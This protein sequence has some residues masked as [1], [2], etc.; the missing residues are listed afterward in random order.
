LDK[1]VDESKFRYPG[2]LPYTKEQAVLMIADSCEAASRSLDNPTPDELMTLVENI[3]ASKIQD[4]QLIYA[5]ITFRDLNKIKT[6]VQ[7]LLINIYHKRIK[8]PDSQ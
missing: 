6:E 7:K 3:V 5:H 2:P 8:Y 4:N 1:S